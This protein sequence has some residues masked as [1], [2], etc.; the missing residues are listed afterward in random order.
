[1]DVTRID[2]RWLRRHLNWPLTGDEVIRIRSI[3][4][5]GGVMGS[6]DQVSCAGRSFIFKGPPDDSSDWGNLLTDIGLREVSTYRF[7]QSRGRSA[8]KVSPECYWSASSRDGRGAL[9]LEDLGVPSADGVMAAGLSR[10]QAGAA[11]RCLAK[12]HSALADTEADPRALPHPWL[13]GVS[14][15]GLLAAISMGLDDLP[16]MIEECWP[17]DLSTTDARRVLDTDIAQV[18]AESHL[19]ARCVSLCHGDV[20]ASNILFVP[21]EPPWQHTA[22][23]IDWQFTMWGNPLSDVA[24]LLLSS[25]TPESRSAWE[26]EL[27]HEYHSTL[28][29]HR[30]LDYTLDDCLDDL[31]RAEPFAAL[32]ALATLDGYTRG[33]TTEELSG[34]AGRVR[35][36]V[37]LV[38]VPAADNASQGADVDVRL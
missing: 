37:D 27:L 4:H 17:H 7:L 35:A 18:V 20:W 23:L 10:A 21:G 36:A 19:G 31:R 8:P 15:E 16:R 9:A 1:M 26:G 13:Y 2:H 33:M 24:L 11:V 38:A 22:L 32:V 29:A 28:T 5:S 3:S 12:A 30:H 25:L 14:S 34:F 6:V